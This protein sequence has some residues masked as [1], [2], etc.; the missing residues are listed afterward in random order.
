MSFSGNHTHGEVEVLSRSSTRVGQRASVTVYFERWLLIGLLLGLLR[1]RAH[2]QDSLSNERGWGSQPAHLWLARSTMPSVELTSSITE[3]SDYN[4]SFRERNQKF[5]LSGLRFIQMLHGSF[6]SKTLGIRC[7][8][9]Y[10]SSSRVGSKRSTHA[11]SGRLRSAARGSANRGDLRLSRTASGKTPRAANRSSSLS[12]HQGTVGRASRKFTRR[13]SK[14]GWLTA[15]ATRVVPESNPS[16]KFAHAGAVIC[17]WAMGRTALR[18]SAPLVN[19][20]QRSRRFKRLSRSGLSQVGHQ[21]LSVLEG[22][23]RRSRVGRY[24]RKNLPSALK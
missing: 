22:N 7:R 23:Q 10:C 16:N 15:T 19:S 6:C 3:A 20:S 9:T 8:I 4:Q 21:G 24:S 17:F 5:R 18:G 11:E 13:R 2:G 12:Q 1:R 14:K